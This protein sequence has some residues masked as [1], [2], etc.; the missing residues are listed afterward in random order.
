MNIRERRSKILELLEKQE[1]LSVKDLAEEFH[2]SVPTLYKDLDNLEQE[3]LIIKKYGEIQ[4]IK[5]DKYKH[6]FFRQLKIDHEQKQLIAAKAINLIH[7]GETIF[8]DASS[9]TYYLCQELKTSKKKNL[10]IVTNSVFIPTELIMYEQYRIISTGGVL[11]RAGAEFISSNPEQYLGNIH[12]NTFFFS[13]RAVSPE[14]GVLDYY[15]PND[16]RIKSLF[17]ENADQAV[18]LAD[19]TKFTKPGTI[20]WVGFDKLKTIVTDNRINPEFVL[21]LEEQGVTVIR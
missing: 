1:N 6:D 16:I 14:K 5:E 9:T 4:L 7:D 12:G 15:H 20:N 21:R 2:V 13:V 3:Q 8:L 10:T 18:L 19:S 17:L 11:E